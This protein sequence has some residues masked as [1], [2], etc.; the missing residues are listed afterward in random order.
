MAVTDGQS[1]YLL[2]ASLGSMFPV[3]Q[4]GRANTGLGRPRAGAPAGVA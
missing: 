3:T 1:R 2:T 4:A